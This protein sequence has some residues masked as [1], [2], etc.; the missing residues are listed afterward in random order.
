MPGQTI[1]QVLEV[2]TDQWMTIPGVEGTAIGLS[3]GKPCILIWSSV[4]AEHLRDK[5]LPMV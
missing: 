1:E 2:H 3:G 4:K 5:M